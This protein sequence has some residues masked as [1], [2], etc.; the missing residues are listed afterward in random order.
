MSARNRIYPVFIPHLGCP[1]ACVFCNQHEITGAAAEEALEQLNSLAENPP[2]EGAYELAF[3]GGSFTAI[4]EA[5]Q[6]RYLEAARR[7][8][9]RHDENRLRDHHHEVM[10]DLRAQSETIARLIQKPEIDRS[11]LS[12]VAG[13]IGR[14]TWREINVG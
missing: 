7:A 14:T 1:H 8:A 4:P 9:D 2:Q 12:T 5:Q 3:Y 11:A 13:I 6:L 10:E